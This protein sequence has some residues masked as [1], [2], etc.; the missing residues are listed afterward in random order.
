MSSS[1]RRV[2]LQQAGLGTT[3]L[4]MSGTLHARRANEKI[5]VGLIGC[6]GR[7]RRFLA[8]AGF[9]C[10]PDATR[11]GEAVK[12]TGVT[13]ARAVTDMRRLL[14]DPSVDAVVIATPDHWHAPAAL[15][16]LEA[17]KH[18]YVEKPC[19]HNF[20]ES[21]LLLDAARR[22]NR[23]V[24]HGTQQRSSPIASET[25]AMLR[26]GV[27][28]NV[29]VAKAWNVQVRPNIGHALPAAI[30]AELN[31]D[32][33]VGP[34][35]FVPFQPNRLHYNWHWWHS[36]GTGDIGNDGTHEIDFARWG[37]GV[38]TLPTK[39]AA[40][41]GKYFHDDDQ[42][43]PDTAVCTFEYPGDD[44][45]G[46][47]RQL[48]FEMRLWSTNYPL[49]CDTGVEFI[50][51]QGKLT[52]SKR[53][54][55]EILGPRN[56]VIKQERFESSKN[57]EHM[58]NFLSAIRSGAPPNAP[59]EEAHRSVALVHLANIAIRTGRS[60]T[61][62]PQ[63]EQILG[64]EEASKMLKRAYRENGHWAIPRGV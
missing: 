56:K 25:I 51:T 26:E 23:V 31:Y 36:F 63:R 29:L 5:V 13:A 33:W 46:A 17:G 6:G 28:G 10:D 19:S 35:P 34:A 60:I 21:Q 18:V 48:I 62:D 12:Q 54:R 57:M 58:E 50:G 16:A 45:A 49:N 59:M 3:A 4:G 9:L 15:L 20:R 47:R 43:F 8:Y 2:F 32:L 52:F 42:Q 24:Q 7:A 53:G 64:D 39:V 40:I 27:I 61:L 55:I 22:S 30:P 41:G 44:K 38:D 37:L 1:S 14:D 11:L